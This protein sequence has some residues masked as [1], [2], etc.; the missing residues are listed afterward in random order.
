MGVDDLLG[1]EDFLE[2]TVVGGYAHPLRLGN[3]AVE[4][5]CPSELAP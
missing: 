1:G 5:A 2:L 4:A 3:V